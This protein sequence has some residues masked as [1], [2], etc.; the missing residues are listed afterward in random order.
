VR[1]FIACFLLLNAPA[2]AEDVFR[3]EIGK[4][5]RGYSQNDLKRRVWELERA[6]AQ[7][8]A[9]VFQL[10]A[11]PTPSPDSWACTMK[12]FGE[13]YIGTGVSKALANAKALDACKAGQKGDSFHCKLVE[14][15]Q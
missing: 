3:I 11:T 14:C 13:T 4:D 5:Y 6:V 12:A 15:S 10:E 8:Q 2:F 1:F 7:L 9:R